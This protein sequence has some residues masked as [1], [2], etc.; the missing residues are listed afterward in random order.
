V[1]LLFG[2][3]PVALFTAIVRDRLF[4]LDLVIVGTLVYGALTAMLATTFFATVFVLQ[5][6]LRELLG[7]PSELAVA[8]AA[9]LN[10][11]LFQPARRR[12]Q[13]RLDRLLRRRPHEAAAA[14]AAFRSSLVTQELDLS[15]LEEQLIAT[16]QQALGPARVGIWL[17]EPKAE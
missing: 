1:P 7:G 8:A 6:L 16:V 2:I 12:L 5:R 9:L 11:L 15:A 14:Q 13:R 10:G 3:V 17:R 4:D